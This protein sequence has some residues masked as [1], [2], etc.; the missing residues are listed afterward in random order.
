MLPATS[1][2]DLSLVGVFPFCFFLNLHLL[3]LRALVPVEQAINHTCGGAQNAET[4]YESQIE[5]S[6]I[7]SIFIPPFP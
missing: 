5:A 4:S 6:G 1:L 2:T 7:P 3:I